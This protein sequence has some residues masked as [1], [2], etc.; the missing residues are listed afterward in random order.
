MFNPTLPLELA[1]TLPATS[2]KEVNQE[3]LFETW[4]YI[5][6]VSTLDRPGSYI[7]RKILN[8]PLLFVRQETGEIKGFYNVCRHHASTLLEG[9]GNCSKIRCPYHGW[10]YALDGTLKG[11]PEFDGVQDFKREENGLVPVHV[12]VVGPFLFA[13]TGRFPTLSAVLLDTLEEEK[14]LVEPL[15]KYAFHSRLEYDIKCNWKVFVDNYLD[16]GYHVNSV[17]PDLASGINYKE[18]RNEL[19]G[20]SVLQ[21]APLK[22]TDAFPGQTRSSDGDAHYWW[23]YPNLMLNIYGDMMDVN[24]VLPTGPT[25]CRVIM[26]FFYDKTKPLTEVKSSIAISEQV[27]REDVR[28]CERVQEGLESGAYSVGRYSVAR[29]GGMYLF[30]QLLTRRS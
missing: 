23:F 11:V 2:Y 1:K 28:I 25:S 29:E 13:S 4:Q 21:I 3:V 12:R 10:T 9:E 5:C 6:P 20:R 30:H 14:S 7:A 24:V 27:Q 15:D 8:K 16:G 19:H 18:Y 17:H 22:P 26:D